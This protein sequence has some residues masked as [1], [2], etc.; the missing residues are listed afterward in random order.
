MLTALFEAIDN[1]DPVTFTSFLSP[2]CCFRFGNLPQVRGATDIQG[3]VASFFN[4]IA[5]LSHR[6][7]EHWEIPGGLVCHGQ[8][9]YTRVDG[10][11]LSVPFANIFKLDVVGICD[12]AI[13]A[14]TSALYA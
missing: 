11:T 8:V 4:S 3:F 13:F 10:S 12:Y 6:I 1:K 14:D 2:D 9:T 5:A 7:E